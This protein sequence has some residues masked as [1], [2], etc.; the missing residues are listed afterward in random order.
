[1]QSQS[2]ILAQGLYE[3]RLLLTGYLGNTDEGDPLVRQAAHL[4]YALHN[5]ALT[6]IE[7]GTFDCQ[8]ALAKV[9]AV[10]RMFDTTFASRF[11]K[12]ASHSE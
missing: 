11:E 4:A 5:E 9:K 7:S 12:H 6:V 10:D 3:I 8:K 2:K 1:M